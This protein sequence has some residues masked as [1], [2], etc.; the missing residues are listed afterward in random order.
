MHQALVDGLHGRIGPVEVAVKTMIINDAHSS[1]Q[2][3]K[4]FE[5]EI[6]IMQK[7][8]QHLNV[9]NLLGVVISGDT[10]HFKL[11]VIKCG[12]NSNCVP[13]FQNIPR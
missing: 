7:T 13:F 8:G 2:I 3:Q 10:L 11:I 4:A 1:G 12:I 6:R 5:D 9:V